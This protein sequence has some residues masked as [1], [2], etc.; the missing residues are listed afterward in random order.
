VSGEVVAVNDAVI[1][2][3]ER[4]NNDA[5]GTWLFCIKAENLSGLGNLMDAHEYQS[6]IDG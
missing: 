5:F 4:V 6:M 2:E 1:D 3:P